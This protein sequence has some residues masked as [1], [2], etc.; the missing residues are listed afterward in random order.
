MNDLALSARDALE[1]F[2]GFSTFKG[3]QEAIIQSILDG[4]DTFVIMPTGGGK[5]LCYQ[6]PAL[7]SEGTAIVVSPLIALMKNQVDALRSFSTD[8]G[9]AHFLNSSLSRNEAL[10]VKKDIKDGRTKLLY[11]APE[12]LT[13]RE[14]IE[15]L[16]DIHISFFAIDEAHCISEWGHDFRPEYRRLRTIFDEIKRV[17]VI[18]LT[19]TATEKVQEDILKN[20]DIPK[21][22][23][24]KASFNRP[25]LYYEVRPKVQVAREIIRFVKQYE[26]RSGIIYCLS[27]KK[28]EEIAETLK[29]NGIKALPYHA[30]MDAAQRADHQDQ[31]LMENVDVIVATIAF[32]MG[33]D[34]PD[35]RFVIHHDIPKSLES[36]YQETGRAGR[37][38]GE[39]RC[40][41]FYSYKDIEKLEKFLQGKPVAEQEIGKQLLQ[42][43]VSYA[44]TSMCRRRFLLHY[45][46]EELE[47]DNC[48][49]CD[50]CLYPKE[51]FDARESLEMLLD[52]VQE[53]KERHRAKFLCDLLTGTESSEMKTYKGGQLESYGKGNDHDARY[54]QGIVR[55]AIVDGY[56]EKDIETYGILTITEKGRKFMK[57]PH[58]VPFLKE[59]DFSEF[60]EGGDEGGPSRGGAAD[61]KLM[62]MLKDL[63]QQQARKFKLAPYVLFQDPS[64]EEMTI[65]YPV[66]V[67]EL[68]HITGVGPG[69]AQKY[70]K[71]FADMIARYVDENEIERTEEVVVRSVVN[72]SG[73]KVQIIQNIDRKLPLDSIARAKGL[74][75]VQLLHELE[76]IVMSGTKLDISY[77][78][79]EVLDGDLQDEIMDYFREAETDSIDAAVDEFNGDVSEEEVRLMRIRFLSE[80]AN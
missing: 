29:V 30:G 38:G 32:G 26:G 12:S 76:S 16:T 40:V 56:L 14:N 71:P 79:D 67:E 41:A 13:K 44:E 10:R 39:G 34:K 36:Y 78:V 50:N 31:F 58:A 47:G 2:F 20:L 54:W 59:R 75:L 55:Q 49:A 61:E 73:S 70:G 45:F 72:K 37:D 22:R 64:L 42:E 25:N 6:L 1:Q 43:T 80:V 68:T 11:V 60:D 9:V 21:A 74:T 27:R 65:R 5:S 17:P 28:V 66:T 57:K 19:A 51:S 18:A 63:R 3:E 7:M 53:S 69:K 35:V 23:V 24:F 77:H 48:G 4:H 46:G 8:S 52:A 33:I 15:F 62:A